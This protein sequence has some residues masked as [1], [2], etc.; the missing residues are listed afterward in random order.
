MRN[1]KSVLVAF[2]LAAAAALPATA[3]ELGVQ[4]STDRSVT[5]AV[6]PQNLADGAGSWD[7]KIVLDTHSADLGDDL[8]KSAILIDGDGRRYTPVAWDGA[9]P[10]GHH[11]EGVL[12]FKPISP[13]PQS[14]EL[15]IARNG[16]A[17]PRAFR[18]QLN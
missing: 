8:T 15:Q 18:W 5:V 17:A 2:V 4:K 9:G 12:R 11:R 3:A 16:E 7:F 1:L 13:R 6:T 14:V 10:G